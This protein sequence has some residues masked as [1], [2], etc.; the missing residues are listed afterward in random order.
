MEGFISQCCAVFISNNRDF[1]RKYSLGNVFE[2]DFKEYWDSK[3]YRALRYLIN[4][5]DKPIPIQCAGCRIF[6]TLPR[7]KEYGI[8]N[9][10]TGEVMSLKKFYHECMGENMKWRYKDII[11]DL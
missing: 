5:P 8:I 1:I 9:T 7:E 11:K 4:K 6:N 10:H 2:K 3:P